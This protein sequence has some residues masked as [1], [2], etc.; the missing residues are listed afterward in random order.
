[1]RAKKSL[2]QNFLKSKAALDAIIG[3]G[4]PTPDDIVL[5]IGPGQ[6]VLT[7]ELLKSAGKVVAIEKDS[8]LIPVLRGNFEKYVKNG[9]LD[10]LEKDILDFDPEISEFADHPYKVIANIPYYITGQVIRK[11]LEA[12]HQPESMT[13]LVQKEVADRIMARDGKESILSISVKA[14]GEPKYIKTV[15][16]GAFAPMPKVDSAIIHIGNIG[17]GRF[18][19]SLEKNFFE[20]LRRGFAHK[21]KL[22]IKNLETKKEIFEK[23]GIP[24]NARAEELKVEDWICLAK[25]LV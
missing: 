2:G 23:C 18:E 15:P 12:E 25:N 9:K 21:R 8:R 14:Y 4:D 16:R 22:L 6:G 5:E 1:M 3:A 10:I 7:T 11:F 13:L 20:I 19:K 17:K 24:Q